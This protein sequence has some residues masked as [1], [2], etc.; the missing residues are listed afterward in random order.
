MWRAYPLALGWCI[1]IR[2]SIVRLLLNFFN[3]FDDIALC[4]TG[5]IHWIRS[6][7]QRENRAVS[8]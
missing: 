6:Q 8:G 2:Y 4:S 7:R 5:H 1:P 3:N